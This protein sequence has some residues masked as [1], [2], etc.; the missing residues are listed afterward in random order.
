MAKVFKI[1]FIALLKFAI[2]LGPVLDGVIGEVD[3]SVLQVWVIVSIAASPN[4]PFFVKV[5]TIMNPV[6]NLSEPKNSDIELTHRR[7][8]PVVASH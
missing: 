4:I 1:D 3:I 8:V 5:T 2:I 7:I 6:Y